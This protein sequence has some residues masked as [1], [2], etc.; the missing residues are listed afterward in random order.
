MRTKASL[1]ACLVWS[2][3][4]YGFPANDYTYR[5][6]NSL[7][8]AVVA[9]RWSTKRRRCR[10]VVLTFFVKG[11]IVDPMQNGAFQSLRQLRCMTEHG[12]ES[13]TEFERVWH[14]FGNGEAMCD[15]P[16]AV[17]HS[18]LRWVSWRWQAPDLYCMGGM[19]TPGPAAWT[20]K[21]VA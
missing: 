21:K 15:G 1:I 20:G 3:A 11:Y 9:A 6:T 10:E 19:A 16:V 4:M 17:T 12:P 14:C 2:A 18:I 13:F 7:W 8:T 5:L